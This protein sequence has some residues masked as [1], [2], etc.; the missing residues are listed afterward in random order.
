MA[1]RNSSKGRNSV[2]QPRA[3]DVRPQISSIDEIVTGGAKSQAEKRLRDQYQDQCRNFA[4]ELAP[5]VDLRRAQRSFKAAVTALG[6]IPSEIV[7]FVNH[8]REEAAVAAREKLENFIRRYLARERSTNQA[9]GKSN[10]KNNRK[11]KTAVPDARDP[12]LRAWTGNSRKDGS[13]KGRH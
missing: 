2:R 1:V 11:R 10:G 9:S 12:L 13:H 5:K 7:F 4:S 3:C 6:F 8:R